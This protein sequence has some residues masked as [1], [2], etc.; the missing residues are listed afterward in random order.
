MWAGTD[1][2]Y[3]RS[4]SVGVRSELSVE[5]G[6]GLWVEKLWLTC[7]CG[8]GHLGRRICREMKRSLELSV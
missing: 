6:S 1:S 2:I 8:G 4:F 7:R 5:K 3:R